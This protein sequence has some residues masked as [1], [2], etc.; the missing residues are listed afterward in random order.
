MEDEQQQAI[1]DAERDQQEKFY[2][3]AVQRLAVVSAVYNRCLSALNV[4]VVDVSRVEMV[5]L[6]LS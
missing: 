4:V 2:Q 3:Q 6:Y 5:D 1:M